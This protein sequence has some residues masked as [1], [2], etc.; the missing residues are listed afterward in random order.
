MLSFLRGS[1]KVRDYLMLAGGVLLLLN[2]RLHH[3]ALHKSSARLRESCC[4]VTT[5]NATPRERIDE[6]LAN[7]LPLALAFEP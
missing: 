2:D 1:V 6:D 5:V 7:E 4:S 3:L